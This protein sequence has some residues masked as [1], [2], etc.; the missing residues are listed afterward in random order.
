MPL[1]HGEPGLICANLE[2]LS[3]GKRV[4]LIPIGRLTESQLQA[5][6]KNRQACGYPAIQAEIVFLGRH[7]YK[8]R[9]AKDGYS[10]DDIVDQIASGLDAASVVP[11]F[12]PMTALKNPTPRP[13]RYGNLVHD[14]AVLECR[15][16]IPDRNC[17]L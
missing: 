15:P 7:A 2:A 4:S 13:D 5:I 6:N 9:A 3:C 14:Q 11:S 8:G 17:S 16:G 10:I 1:Y 12:R